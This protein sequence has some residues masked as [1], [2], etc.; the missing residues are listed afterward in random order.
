MRVGILTLPFNNNY[1]GYLQAYALMTVLKNNGYDV[2]LI[3]RRPNRPNLLRRIKYFIKNI[4]KRI[5]GIKTGPIFID[6]EYYY[7]Y[8][9]SRI[10]PFVDKYIY[11]K[12]K[13]VYS[14]HELQEV[15]KNRYDAVIV[16][17]DQVWRPIYV[18]N[19]ENYF[20][21]IIIDKK[22][23]KIAYAASFGTDN[24][25]F[26]ST[27]ISKCGE[28]IKDFEYISIREKGGL[29]VIRK[30]GWELP[31]IKVV[32][33]PTMLLPS[34]HYLKFI[35]KDIDKYIATYILDYNNYKN[36]LVCTVSDVLRLKVVSAI[37]QDE[38]LPSMEEWLSTIYN[39]KF[40]ITDSYHGTVFSIL[41]N[42]P[43][44]VIVNKE[45]GSERFI[46]L[47]EMFDLS[48]RMCDNSNVKEV[49][50]KEINWKN[51][52]SI[53]ED[54]RIESYNFIKEALSN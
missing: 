23:R 40:V 3:N 30:F 20:L 33:D 34:N 42:R 52:N 51:V 2:E 11:P 4:I 15:M 25:E 10:M 41:F 16:G 50:S 43:F 37:N 31:E 36:S 19:I 46:S 26:S 35:K 9:G 27:Q 38:L 45:R 24:P 17:S 21:D 47:L 49:I 29:N 22:V 6:P 8:R 32:L 13:A 18:P 44:I 7:R 1:G 5:M 48:Y 54:K 28:L 12:T 14:V 39:S 53:L